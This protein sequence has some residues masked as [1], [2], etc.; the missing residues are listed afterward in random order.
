MALSRAVG[1]AVGLLIILF[2]PA[3]APVVVVG[4][5]LGVL[6]AENKAI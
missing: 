3:L 6:H 4:F 5:L 2:L 1:L